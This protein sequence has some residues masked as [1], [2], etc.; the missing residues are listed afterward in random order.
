MKLNFKKIAISAYALFMGLISHADEGMWMPQLIKKLNEGDMKKIGFKL[1][2]EDLYSVNKSSLKDAIGHFAGGCTSEL[3]SPEGLM[4]TNH[5]CGY[6]QI[7]FHSTVANNYL[8]DGFWAKNK[9]EELP[10][11]G[12]TVSF[13][14]RI[15]D[16]SKQVLDGV[17]KT[18]TEEERAKK[19]RRK[20]KKT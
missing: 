20:F 3:V 6:D 12:L 14:V 18:M 10:C 13:I 15:D 11:A 4:L 8:R 2:A 7:Q 1:T 5:H 17:T 9:G 19:D 16:V